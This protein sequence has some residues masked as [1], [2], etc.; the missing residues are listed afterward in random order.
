MIID[1][2]MQ[3]PTLRFAQ[4]LMFASLMRW[5]RQVAPAQEIPV[6]LIRPYLAAQLVSE[7]HP[8]SRP[9]QYK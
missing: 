3:H 7:R 4:H 9:A 1:G 2:W 8:L 6:A 5:T